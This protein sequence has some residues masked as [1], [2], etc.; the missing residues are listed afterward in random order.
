MFFTFLLFTSYRVVECR[1]F[2]IV[3]NFFNLFVFPTNTFKKCF[4]IIRNAYI[5]K[6]YRTMR[7]CIRLQK[8]VCSIVVICCCHTKKCIFVLLL[9]SYVKKIIAQ[10]KELLFN[11]YRYTFN[12]K[13]VSKD[14]IMIYPLF[15]S[16]K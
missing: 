1:R 2:T 11:F 4:F 10:T 6:W 13:R 3:N 5:V 8:G 9:Q 14:G 15:S 7:S 16:T 12:R